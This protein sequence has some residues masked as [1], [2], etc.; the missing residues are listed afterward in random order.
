MAPRSLIM[1]PRFLIMALRLLNMALRLLNMAVRLMTESN[2]FLVELL[3]S[4]LYTVPVTS[5]VFRDVSTS[6]GWFQRPPKVGFNDLPDEILQLVLRHFVVMGRRNRFCMQKA[7]WYAAKRAE[8]RSEGES[9]R[10]PME[11]MY[12]YSGRKM[13]YKQ[14]NW[15][16]YG[17]HCQD[18]VVINTTNRA[19]RRVGKEVFVCNHLSPLQPFLVVISNTLLLPGLF[20]A[21][22]LLSPSLP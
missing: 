22:Q 10:E 18:W 9:E 19:I 2:L 16:S 13:W 3:I 7:E 11:V 14:T 15:L 6:R 5:H 8:R 12:H 1:A 20:I 21:S 4:S 17:I